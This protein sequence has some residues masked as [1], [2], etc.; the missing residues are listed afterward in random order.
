VKEAE[1]LAFAAWPES[2]VA[3]VDLARGELDA[4]RERLEYAFALACEFRDPCWEGFACRGLGL[5]EEQNGNTAAA[6]RQLEDARQRAGRTNDAWV[7]GEAYALEA[8]AQV[9]V[10]AE[11]RKAESLVEDL[12]SLAGRTGMREMAVK[13]LLMRHQLGDPDALGAA[14][15]I[16][17]EVENPALDAALA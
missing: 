4:A 7:W 12:R 3:E 15:L 2:L 13:A 10:R 11:S 1:W 9:A 14:R 8:L 6:L 16:A 17:A 5:I